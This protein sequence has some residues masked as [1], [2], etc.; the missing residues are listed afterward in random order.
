MPALQNHRH[1]LVAKGLADGLSYQLI[2]ERAGYASRQSVGVL[3]CKY[4]NEIRGR[5]MELRRER[6]RLESYED[7]T[8]ALASVRDVST[9]D[10]W[11]RHRLMQAIDSALL[12]DD[13][14]MVMNLTAQL[15]R[16]A[17]LQVDRPRLAGKPSTRTILDNV[18]APAAAE[19]ELAPLT[20][21][22]EA[23]ADADAE[24]FLADLLARKA[25]RDA[26]NNESG[27]AE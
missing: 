24:K 11:L 3:I 23:Q 7:Q 2:A 18:A 20:P 26:G 8:A 5:A 17:G 21:E 19:P 27:S 1:E 6:L 15:A 25:A 13:L 22:E 16:I 9:T 10:L 14:D 4:S 12:K